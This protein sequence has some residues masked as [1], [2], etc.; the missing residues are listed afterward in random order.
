MKWQKFKLISSFFFLIKWKMHF[1]K[2][3]KFTFINSFNSVLITGSHK[4]QLNIFIENMFVAILLII[5]GIL[6]AVTLYVELKKWKLYP[7][8][9]NFNAVKNLP[10]IGYARQFI[11]KTSDEVLECVNEIFLTNQ[12][13]VRVWLGPVLLIG[14]AEP[15]DLQIILNADECLSKP[16]MYKQM[17]C[18]TSLISSE[19]EIWK[20]H[21]RAL[22]TAFNKKIIMSHFP[23]LNEKLEI[24]REQIE[25][26][27][28]KEIT[29][30]PFLFKYILDIIGNLALDAEEEVQNE[31]GDDVYVICRTLL[32]NSQQRFIKVWLQWDCIYRLTR[33]SRNERIWL[34]K[35]DEYLRIIYERK[36]AKLQQ[37]LQNGVDTLALGKSTNTLSVIERCFLMLREGILKTEDSLFDQ[38]R[39]I[40]IAGTETSSSTLH[41]SLIMLAIHQDI[42][43]KLLFELQHIL[44]TDD[45][46][47]TYEHICKMTYMDRFVKEVMRLFAPVP[48][49]ARLC[50]GDIQLASGIIPKNT[51]ITA[52]I[53][54]MHRDPK[55]WGPNAHKF[56]P[57]NFLPEK[58]AQRHPYSYIPFSGGPRNCIGMRYAWVDIKI[59]LA[60]LLRRYRFNTDLKMEDIKV[61]VNLVIQVTNKNP[62]K[63]ERRIFK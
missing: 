28:N 50:T 58:V 27:E 14:V 31:K 30:F 10:L 41:N 38:M 25:K 13:P 55:I 16:Y 48:F 53:Y 2:K 61:K 54:S 19:K 6:F 56:D 24:F 60:Y 37:N 18:S 34:E 3:M 21:R 42:Q 1:R 57:D 7:K 39:V 63:F 32:D 46:A 35:A 47:I 4:T 40:I 59:T 29:L 51:I 62:Y 22:N 15:D 49:I 5:F 33:E 44:E 9:K 36:K 52:N 8:I 45:C 17:H 12:T 20:P 23:T 26:Y 43:E 11:G